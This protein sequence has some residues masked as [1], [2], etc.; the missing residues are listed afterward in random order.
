L[1]HP[2][3]PQL[4]FHVIHGTPKAA[5]YVPKKWNMGFNLNSAPFSK[6]GFQPSQ[7]DP[8]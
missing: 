3:N 4:D 6:H 5:P 8:E 2:G 7:A 1:Q